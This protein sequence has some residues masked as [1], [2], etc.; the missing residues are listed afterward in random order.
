MIDGARL[1]GKL[2]KPTEFVAIKQQSGSSI[3][4][5]IVNGQNYTQLQIVGSKIGAL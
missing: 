4:P 1:G 2:P 5:E 3:I